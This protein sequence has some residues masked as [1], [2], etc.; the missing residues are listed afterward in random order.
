MYLATA[1]AL[2]FLSSGGQTVRICPR[3][4]GQTMIR[5]T[6]SAEMLAPPMPPKAFEARLAEMA[7]EIQALRE[8]V[9]NAPRLHRKDVMARYGIARAHFAPVDGEEAPAG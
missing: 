4:R 8:L 6:G 9:V 7:A 1:P 3:I 2:S 5:G